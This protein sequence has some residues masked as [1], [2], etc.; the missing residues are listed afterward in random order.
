MTN[1]TGARRAMTRSPTMTIQ[2]SLGHALSGATP[3]SLEH[4]ESASADFRCYIND[5]LAG[6][7]QALAASP[8]M[9]MAHVLVAYLNLLGTE[10][11]GI[12]VARE[13]LQ[14]AQALPADEREAMHLRAVAHLVNGRWHAAG[15]VL[16]DLSI[17]YPL[18]LLA[19]QAGHQVDFFTG[20]SRMLCDRIARAEGAWHGGMG[21]YR[22]VQGMY[23][24]GLEE[25]GGYGRAEA[26]GRRAVS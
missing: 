17:R 26:V 21:G 7:Q 23:A 13:A 4:Y 24:F 5:P 3:Q 1:E 19:L 20:H 14:A 11:A 25:T 18:D 9:T 16:E 15:L 6:A 22:A 10:P 8:E 2:D 12:A